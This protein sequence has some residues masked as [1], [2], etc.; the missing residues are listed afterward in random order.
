MKKSIIK[1]IALIFCTL[2]L[3]GN[4]LAQQDAMYSQYM[5]N[6]LTVNPAY[7]GSRDVLS[8]TAMYRR[9][10]LNIKGAPTTA[11]ISADMPLRK[12]K[13][14]LGLMIVNDKIGITNTLGVYGSYAY[15]IKLRDRGVLALGLS[16]GASNYAAN[17]SSVE[18]NPDGIS[19]PAFSQ[20]LSKWMPN[21]GGGIYYSTDRFYAGAS[22]P[23]L[24]NNS[25]NSTNA[26]SLGTSSKNASQYRHLFVMAGYVFKISPTVVCKPSFLTKYVAN[27]PIQIDINA[28]FWFQD[29]I[30][31]GASYRS[32]DGMVAMFECQL[33]SQL[34]LGYAYE[35]PLTR[36]SKY[37]SGSHEIL[38]RYE[39]GFDKG[40]ILSPRYF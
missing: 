24:L 32:A 34:R 11:L 7:A 36:L 14:G 26:I 6:M 5:F 8:T 35:F 4:T 1:I 30:G 25:L 12:E 3:T 18:S 16:A 9:Q 13:M 33:N 29:K 31:I 40:Q 15:R 17:L 28:N 27:S 19:D 22:L 39:F 21:F 38:L 2:V 10:W 20:N 37:T 23:H